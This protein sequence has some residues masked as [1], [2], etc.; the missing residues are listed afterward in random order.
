MP[1]DNSPE[2]AGVEARLVSAERHAGSP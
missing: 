2:L 1:S